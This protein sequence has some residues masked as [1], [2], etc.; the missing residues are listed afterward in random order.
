MSIDT[1]GVCE[2]MWRL[3]SS[4]T[5]GGGPPWNGP[6]EGGPLDCGLKIGGRVEVDCSRRG[7]PV[8][9]GGGTWICIES[10]MELV[11]LEVK[12]ANRIS[13]GGIW[14]QSPDIVVEDDHHEPKEVT[15]NASDEVQIS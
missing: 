9:P 13:Q 10:I 15:K 12:Y 6:G 2:G 11:D 7:G 1:K 8:S 14:A 3:S 5:G 4:T